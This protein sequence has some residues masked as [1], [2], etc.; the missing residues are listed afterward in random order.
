MMID[1]PLFVWKLYAGQHSWSG[2]VRIREST[3]A[4]GEEFINMMYVAKTLRA[5]V[6]V[7]QQQINSWIMEPR[8]EK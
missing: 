2:G 3:K 5:R 7:R 4:A 6:T 8:T 1:A